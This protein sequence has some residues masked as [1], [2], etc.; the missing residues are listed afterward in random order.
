[1]DS[2]KEL[3]EILDSINAYIKEIFK[4]G[5]WM[6]EANP[7]LY[8]YDL[9]CTAILN[10]TV[11]FHKAYI[12]LLKD[13]NF[14]AAAPL[15]RIHM[16]SLLRLFASRII[17]YNVDEFANKVLNGM[18]IVDL[19]DRNQKKMIDGHLV[20]ELSKLPDMAWVKGIY[21]QGSGYVHF[22]NLVTQQSFGINSKESLLNGIIRM[23]DDLVPMEEKI[24]ASIT[25][26]KISNKIA[27]FIMDWVEQKR[28][29]NQEIE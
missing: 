5:K 7:N 21:K 1:M 14:I 19:K 9:F 6:L 3:E 10:R 22:S 24:A 26:M 23:N 16:D 13:N 12:S 2:E 29:Y 28:S 20:N 17:D 15:V 18:R 8:S 27:E 25:M 11:N 4:L